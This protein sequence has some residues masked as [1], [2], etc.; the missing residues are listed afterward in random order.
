MGNDR[1][2]FVIAL[3]AV[4]AIIVGGWV[5]IYSYSDVNP[6]F[7]IV[8]S[9]SMQHCQEDDKHSEIGVI[10]TGDLI[11]VKNKD[12]VD[13]VS[14]VEGSSTGYSTFG[15]YGNV[16]VYNRDNNQKPVIHRAFLWLD[17]NGDGTWSAPA[18]EN[19]SG[20]WE[21]E[22]GS[23]WNRLFG[24]ITFYNVGNVVDG[25]KRLEIN[26][27]NINPSSGFLTVGDSVSNT[28]FDQNSGISS[29]RLVSYG[30]IKS[31][32]WAEIPWIG[33]VKLL[34][35][36]DDE[37]NIWANNSIMMLFNLVLLIIVG[38]LAP[39]YLLDSVRYKKNKN[40]KETEGC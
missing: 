4:A 26:L 28:Y 1:R 40:Q 35:S 14:Y 18:L 36:G 31:I 19:Y 30:N 27:D 15:D 39:G 13:I 8:N 7:T 24:N 23:D 32:A 5:A 34:I 22:S 2:N 9:H 12:N 21:C 29:Y 38:I 37:I 3:I 16:I 25:G 10:D 17:Y 11:F 6:P 20:R 33:A